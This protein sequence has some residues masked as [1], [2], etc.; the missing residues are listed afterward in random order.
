M[1][2]YRDTSARAASTKKAQLDAAYEN[3]LKEFEIKI[4]EEERDLYDKI[5][6]EEDNF[7]NYILEEEEKFLKPLSETK[8][9]FI[10]QKEQ[11]IESFRDIQSKLLERMYLN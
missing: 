1:T 11:S 2:L 8:L 6:D 5:N 7:M 4:L 9:K 10:A 3:W